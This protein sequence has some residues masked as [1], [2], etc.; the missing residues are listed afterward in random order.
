M[1]KKNE[2]A[3]ETV[4]TAQEV[5]EPTTNTPEVIAH[6]TK[7]AGERAGHNLFVS[8]HVG[9]IPVMFRF[10]E[11]NSQGR[12]DLRITQVCVG[13]RSGIHKRMTEMIENGQI[14]PFEES[15]GRTFDK[16]GCT[17]MY[18]TINPAL[19]PK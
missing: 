17:Q 16:K 2:K 18:R 13:K 5:Q 12:I 19:R 4:E 15:I 14:T 9:T 1:S 7:Q 10:E 11:V 6:V 8:G 3:V